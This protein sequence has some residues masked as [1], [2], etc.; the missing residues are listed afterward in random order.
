MPNKCGVV[1]CNGNY[2]NLNKCRVFK[3]PRDPA[4]QEQWIS[5]IPHRENFTIQPDKFFICE[6]HWP[7]NLAFTVAPGGQTRPSVPPSLFN[8]PPSCLPSEK[9]KPRTTNKK[10]AQLEYFLQKDIIKDFKDFKPE[11]ELAKKYDILCHRSSSKL[12]IL[13]MSSSFDH[14]LFN[15]TVTDSSTLTAP[16]TVSITKDG[17]Y[18][19]LSKFL[20][21]NNGLRH[22]SQF[23]ESINFAS[24]WK[25]SLEQQLSRI[26]DSLAE[27]IELCDSDSPKHARLQFLKRQVQ[28][29]IKKK[30][31]SSDYVFGVESY[32]K[33]DY[34][35]L[36][37]HL[38]LP[39]KRKLQMLTSSIEIEPVLQKT[40]KET[41]NEM[42]KNSLLLIDEVK[43]R[44]LLIYGG[45]YLSGVAENDK[46]QKATSMLCI[47]CK[48]LHRGPSIMISVIP[49]HRLTAEFQFE[50]VKKAAALIENCG[51]FVIGSITDNH[52]IN[53]R[54]NTL[55]NRRNNYS[56]FH[57]LD[58]KRHWYLLYDT[59]HLL[60]CI[61]NN[62]ISEKSQMLSFDGVVVGNFADVKS[63]YKSESGSILKCTPLTRS[64]VYP[65]RLEL[66]NVQLALRVFNEKVISA[67]RKNGFES[68]AAFIR[69]VLDWWHV[70]NVSSKGE[71]MRFHDS[72]RSVQTAQ[73]DSLDVIFHRF[74]QAP[75]GF[76]KDRIKCLT[77]DTK[78]ALLQTTE[79][80]IFLCQH[81][82]KNGF[83][84][85]LLRE[86]QSD[87]IEGEF[88]VY[89]QSTGSNSFMTSADVMHSFRR[90]LVRYASSFLH[91]I[92]HVSNKQHECI[93]ECID[94]RD[95]GSLIE[96]ALR[97]TKLSTMEM[98]AC[99]YVSGWLESKENEFSSLIEED[100]DPIIDNDDQD[101][102][103]I[104]SRGG[105]KLPHQS[106]VLLVQFSLRFL[107]FAKHRAC[108]RN[109]LMTIIEVIR[110]S[111]NF[112]Q[113][114][115]SMHKR[116]AN[117]LLSGMHNLDKDLQSNP[118]VQT[119]IKKAR[120]AS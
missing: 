31:I 11:K 10:D 71:D 79:C 78:R 4:E 99:V 60:K 86:I 36:R 45:G 101:F 111:Y 61:R 49:V 85:V 118:G 12:V 83:N 115:K 100:D 44:P 72:F 58:S 82:L 64:S 15:C 32:P 91:Y 23:F 34:E 75:S 87:R 51:G 93:D 73:S 89:R 35:L 104:L 14:V 1:N 8:V 21:R 117:V 52:K 116:L 55:F 41:L 94:P 48:C 107:K 62:W 54:Y 108:C 69:Q 7:P 56:A 26:Y 109:R 46:G 38:V 25:P 42:Q 28:L 59:V 33:C 19:P 24:H 5:C 2:N 37:Q 95:D 119:S 110:S 67:L 18:V 47:M 90:R 16:L 97:K 76:G 103:E 70:V 17:F 98:S 27:S 96:I 105:L 43:I 13:F 113:Y 65:N 30:F 114:S 92:E 102:T 29:L 112:G 81:L 9:P 6:R 40:F 84:Y 50:T 3:L 57:P 88:S 120:L 53:Q 39:S 63:L 66:Q 106:T 20:H 68:T 80:Q 77:H 74:T 22:F